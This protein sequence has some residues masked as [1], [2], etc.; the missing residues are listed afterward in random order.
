[1]GIFPLRRSLPVLRCNDSSVALPLIQ[2]T[3]QRFDYLYDLMD[4]G[5]DAESIRK[6]S[7]TFGH[8]PLIDINPINS[9]KLK[10]HIA[11]QKEEKKK[12][13]SFNLPL[14]C[15]THHY[16]QRSMAERV[17]AYLKDDFGCKTI[18]YQGATKVASV[19][20]FGIL[21]ICIHQALKLVT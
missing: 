11:L 8:R 4:A 1:M 20:S 12:F 5:Y 6:Y 18:Y 17:N 19:L 21:S 16:N 14:S 3:S 10:E 7:Q 9:Q 15:D 2:K 13:A